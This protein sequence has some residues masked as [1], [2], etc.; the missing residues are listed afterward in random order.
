MVL[1][2]YVNFHESMSA[3]N[4]LKMWW[5]NNIWATETGPVKYKEPNSNYFSKLMVKAVLVL[6]KKVIHDII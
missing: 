5:K 1:E 4:F 6:K 3:L 2:Q